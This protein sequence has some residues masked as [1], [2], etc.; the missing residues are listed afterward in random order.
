MAEPQA[1]W[2]KKKYERPS[3]QSLNQAVLLDIV[4]S[5]LIEGIYLFIIFSHS[6]FS[7]YIS[8]GLERDFFSASSSYLE[9][10]CKNLWTR[11]LRLC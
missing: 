1:G 7:C 6:L 9:N 3:T 4:I 11:S 8:L 10:V 2:Y 5:L